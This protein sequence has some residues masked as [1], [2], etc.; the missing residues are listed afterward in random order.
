[1][2]F[3]MKPVEAIRWTG[4]NLSEIYD[5][6][7][8]DHAEKA[9]IEWRGRDGDVL[10]VETLK[11]LMR[12]EYGDWIIRGVKGELYLCKPDIFDATYE[13]VK[14]T[15]P[16]ANCGH[17]SDHMNGLECI[18]PGCGCRRKTWPAASTGEEA[19]RGE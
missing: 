2:R 7:S 1:M 6:A 5:F 13:P 16:C 10:F 8:K 3:R 17:K 12:A 15:V 4:K 14:E 19:D 18:F 9:P 11:G